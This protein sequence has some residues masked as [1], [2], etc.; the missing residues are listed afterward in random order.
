MIG[1]AIAAVLGVITLFV[2]SVPCAV[3]L[4][5]LFYGVAFLIQL[6]ATPIGFVVGMILFGLAMKFAIE[7]KKRS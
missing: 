7:L 1:V 5:L 2:A 6:F 4:G 3:L